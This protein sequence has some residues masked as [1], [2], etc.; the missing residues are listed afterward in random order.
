VRF[1]TPVRGIHIGG[2]VDGSTLP[3]TVGAHAHITGSKPARYVGY[4]CAQSKRELAEFLLH[5]LAHLAANT[6]HDDDWRRSVHRLGGRVPAAYKK[7]PR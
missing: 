1:K 6:G 3:D 5:E 2:C 4:I 7:R